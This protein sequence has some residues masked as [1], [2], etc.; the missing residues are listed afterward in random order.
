[1]L[2]GLGYRFYDPRG[3]VGDVEYRVEDIDRRRIARTDDLTFNGRPAFLSTI[4]TANAIVFLGAEGD[5]P[6][7]T[8]IFYADTGLPVMTWRYATREIAEQT[9]QVL[10]DLI[11]DEQRRAVIEQMALAFGDD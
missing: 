4:L 8:Q 7:E 5:K 9:H 10:V 1:M 3:N 6:F 11:R 2:G